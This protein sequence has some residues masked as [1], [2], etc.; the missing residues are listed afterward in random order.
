MGLFSGVRLVQLDEERSVAE[1]P[2]S[3]RNK[4]PFGSMYFAVQSMA[5]ELSTAA[6]VFMA[7]KGLDIDVAVIIID[8]KAE[9]LKQARSNLS[10]QCLEY[11]KINDAIARLNG[12]DAAATVDVK[13]MGKD[14]AGDVVSVFYFTWSF[15]RRE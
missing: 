13:T 9:F 5:A 12:V 1:A 10:F 7:L 2:D 11:E 8:V 14:E 6:P 15:R 3:W 4:N